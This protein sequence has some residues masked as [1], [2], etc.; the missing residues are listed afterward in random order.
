MTDARME[1]ARRSD[2]SG[3]RGWDFRPETEDREFSLIWPIL[4]VLFVAVIVA[5]VAAG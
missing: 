5:G 2:Q 4:A 1:Y 3:A